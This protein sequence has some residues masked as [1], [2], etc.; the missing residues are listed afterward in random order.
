[1]TIL[2]FSRL[3][4][5]HIGGVE[6]HVL[7][8]SEILIKKGHKVIIITEQHD[9]RLSFKQEYSGIKIYRIPFK[10]ISKESWIKKF[11]IWF[12]FWQNRELI[13]DA[14]II[15]CHDVFFWYLPFRFLYPR[16]PVYTTFHGY[17]GNDLP[18]TKAIFM[19][20][21]A[22]KL[23]R[24]NICVGDYLKK[25]YGTKPNYVTYG[26]TDIDKIRN[27]K[28][29]NN[30]LRI[31]NLKFKILFIGR[32]EEETGISIYL[33]TLKIL[34]EKKLKFN[35]TVFGDGS[36]KC[37]AKEFCKKNKLD[38]KFKGFIDNAEK[39]IYSYDYVFTSRYL[40][41]IESLAARKNVFAVYN[42]KIK[43]DYLKMTPFAKWIVIEKS[44]Q[45]LFREIENL[46][47]YEIKSIKKVKNAYDWAKNATW[48]KV[49][50]IYLELWNF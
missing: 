4:Y 34:N 3:F 35:F 6:K 15:H 18:S 1:M 9:K 22:E 27:L 48:K 20:K 7:K 2:F 43:N 31:K 24:G 8:I 23:S 37:K 45:K 50:D 39:Y 10:F 28:V 49:A 42:N 30:R 21:I 33:E 36:L 11:N 13:K 46:I 14:D 25:W 41:I 19:H 32:L 40:G 38:V 47:T 12:W 29:N 17:E 44:P 16:K 26:A 5:P